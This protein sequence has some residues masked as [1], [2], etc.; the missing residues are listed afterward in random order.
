VDFAALAKVLQD[1]WANVT[2]WEVFGNI[3][4]L[5]CVWLYS[6]ENLWA[7]P[8]ALVNC[9]L[10]LIM[11][12][13]ARLY[14]DM[15]LQFIFFILTV[16]GWY[17]WLRGGPRKTERKITDQVAPGERLVLI[18]LAEIVAL[19]LAWYFYT[20]TDAA[21]PYWDATILAYSLVAQWLLNHKVIQ[22]WL[23]WCGVNVLTVAVTSSRGLYIT[24]F[25]YAI[26][27]VLAARG[28]LAWRRKLRDAKAAPAPGLAEVSAA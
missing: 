19:S 2:Y 10:F 27:L 23:I 20:H 17:E 3:T 11:F 6:R 8:V 21:A 12:Y 28:Y 16:I 25:V 22:N 13:Q 24:S 15:L 9:V 7:W 4:L 26:L 5:W 1:W 14:S 18:V